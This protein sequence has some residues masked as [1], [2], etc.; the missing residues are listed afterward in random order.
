MAD[1]RT[2][3][4]LVKAPRAPLGVCR[5]LA[6]AAVLLSLAAAA[7]GE[8]ILIVLSGDADP[9]NQAAAALQESP[10]LKGQAFETRQ[11]AEVIAAKSL[12][13]DT[14]V[15][16][17]IGSQAAV[18]LK[19]Q[20]SADQHMVFCMVAD[21]EGLFSAR[22]LEGP[23]NICGVSTD[24]KPANQLAIIRE[25]MPKARRMGL[26]YDSRNERSVRLLRRAQGEMLEGTELVAVDV[27]GHKS[28]GQA[29]EALFEK[30][31]DVA[32]TMPDSAVYDTA[33]TRTL[34]LRAIR[35]STPVFG[36]SPAFVRAGALLG[37]GV[38][39][40]GQGRQAAE[41]VASLLAGRHREE[42][43]DPQPVL[44]V[45]LIVAEKL[46]VKLPRSVV[47]RA[48]YVFRPQ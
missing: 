38:E 25:A 33:T 10:Q 5:A 48:A 7:R 1:G 15:V 19:G 34:L 3:S 43:L 17:A 35:S 47:E 20:L 42:V 26:L 40:A 23:A 44:A 9:Y 46:S 16:V 2:K 28:A 36:F 4:V 27:A 22:D 12:P 32:W 29:V 39:P 24:I 14:H 18:W 8:A 6:A 21:A 13:S 41:I 30:R 11:L 45:N 31:I 37:V